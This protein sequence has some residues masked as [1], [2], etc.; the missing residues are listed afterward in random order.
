MATTDTPTQPPESYRWPFKASAIFIAVLYAVGLMRW[1]GYYKRFGLDFA[2]VDH[3]LHRV[4][5]PSMYT[6]GMLLHTLIILAELRGFAALRRTTSN[7]DELKAESKW[8]RSMTVIWLVAMVYLVST[9][10]SWWHM[11]LA[12]GFG[13][14][15]G[16]LWS[17]IESRGVRHSPTLRLLL[18][19]VLVGLMLGFAHVLGWL[20]ADVTRLPP[21]KYK[22]SYENQSQIGLLVLGD[23]RSWF[24][25]TAESPS[26]L[27]I[28]AD[29]MEYV[30]FLKR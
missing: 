11:L 24:L 1:T 16:A 20:Q 19:W 7:S 4:L 2:L 23:G 6:A 9:T 30:Q 18:C 13:T 14:L 27:I 3:N 21:V 5:I 12:V 28:P 26:I 25:F 8:T 22:T 15:L 10:T 29:R 17:A